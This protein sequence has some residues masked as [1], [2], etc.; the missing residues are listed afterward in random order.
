MTGIQARLKL[1]WSN[2]QLD[3]DLDLSRNTSILPFNAP[4][5]EA[6]E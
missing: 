2:F 5:K 4:L 3:F 6:H 1:D